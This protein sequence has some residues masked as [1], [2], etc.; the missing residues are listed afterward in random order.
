VKKPAKKKTSKTM[1]IAFPNSEI[2]FEGAIPKEITVGVSAKLTTRP[3]ENISIGGSLTLSIVDPKVDLNKL[4][5]DM[6]KSQGEW[7]NQQAK[8]V[9][10]KFEEE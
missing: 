5:A 3:Y 6:L 7:L 2:V 10:K 9:R 1:E 4:R 8:I